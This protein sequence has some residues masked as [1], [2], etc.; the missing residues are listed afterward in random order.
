V[1]LPFLGAKDNF[2]FTLHYGD[3]YG[4]QLKGG[5]K[6]AA[7]NTG[8]SDLET[9]GIFGAYGGIQHFWCER[10]R[11]NLV[12]GFVDVDNPGFVAGDE[13]DSTNTSPLI[14]YGLLIK[15]SLSAL[16]ISGVDE[17]TKTAIPGPPIDCF[18]LPD[19]ISEAIRHN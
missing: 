11:S 8:S 1:G 17:R 13:L 5:P 10:V 18:F 19:L 14:L 15:M 7:F 9:I 6:E 16:N 3:G 4:T 12:Y 2:K